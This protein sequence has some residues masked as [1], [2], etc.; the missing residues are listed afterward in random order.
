MAKSNEKEKTLPPSPLTAKL[1]RSILFLIPVILFTLILAHVNFH[2]TKFRVLQN[3][4]E[5]AEEAEHYSMPES[6]EIKKKIDPNTEEILQDSIKSFKDFLPHFSECLDH[7]QSKGVVRELETR[8]F[9]TEIERLIS[10]GTSSELF[11]ALISGNGEASK[12]L[13]VGLGNGTITGLNLPHIYLKKNIVTREKVSGINSIAENVGQGLSSALFGVID[14]KAFKPSA[15]SLGLT[16]RAIGEGAGSGAAAGL[17]LKALDTE[18]FNNTGLPGIARNLAQGL[19]SSFFGGVDLKASLTSAM[20]NLSSAQVNAAALSLAQGLGSGAVSAA[21]LTSAPLDNAF[22]KEGIN[23]IAGSLGQ[24]MTTSFIQG[25]DIKKIMVMAQGGLTTEQA[26]QAVLA[27]AQGLGSGAAFATKL[28]TTPPAAFDKNG[29]SG[30]AGSVG[31]GLST[32]FLQDI[33]FR[34]LAS[35]MM[36]KVTLDQ[37]LEASAGLGSGLAEGAA[38]GIGLQTTDFSPKIN[39]QGVGPVVEKFAK[40]L[41]QSFLANGTVLKIVDLLKNSQ[42]SSNIDFGS[43]AKG[44]AIGL[45]GGVEMSFRN[46]G[47]VATILEMSPEDA[48][49]M[50]NLPMIMTEVN[51]TIGGAATGFGSGLGLETTKFVLQILGKPALNS[52]NGI[53][54]ST[55]L[56]TNKMPNPEVP[57]PAMS[58]IDA[59]TNS[60]LAKEAIVTHFKNRQVVNSLPIPVKSL[61][62]SSTKMDFSKINETVNPLLKAGVDRLGCQGVGGLFAVLLA[63]RPDASEIDPSKMEELQKQFASKLSFANQVFNIHDSKSGNRVDINFAKFE[64]LVNGNSLKKEIIVLVL[65]IFLGILTFAIVIPIVLIIN[66]TRNFAVLSGRTEVFKNANKTQWTIALAIILPSSLATLVFGLLA[67]GTRNHFYSSH[68]IIGIILIV[69]TLLAFPLAYLRLK[70]DS[71]RLPF[72]INLAL[73]LSLT[74][75]VLVNGFVDLSAISFCVTQFVPQFLF[76][77]FGIILISPLL[78]SVVMIC[79]DLLLERWKVNTPHIVQSSEYFIDSEKAR[80]TGETN[81][82]VGVGVNKDSFMDI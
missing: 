58:G 36:P 3:P 10:S 70:S 41:T 18:S 34:A 55:R 47:G 60:N 33:N 43:V 5:N 63:L 6:E 49:Q 25:I 28:S 38:L 62:S 67:D 22:N 65:H 81:P 66:S 51:D 74:V 48:A 23:G 56:Q 13:G 15:E 4:L 69:L 39:K 31:Q 64:L 29:V 76:V 54:P 75:I 2:L 45:V 11:S 30:V 21:N 12:F 78:Q 24:G 50:T 9:T 8:C 72:S 59:Q 27:L 7:D 44:F 16:S 32:S 46:S 52:N 53:M 82:V 79:I 40:G 17:N 73:V 80:L 19:T 77:L 20:G 26:N 68:G 14:L 57:V 71:L 35:S 37:I 1:T 42:S 61:A